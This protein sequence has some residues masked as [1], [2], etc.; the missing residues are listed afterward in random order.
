MKSR[1]QRNA[2]RIATLYRKNLLRGG[3]ACCTMATTRWLRI[4][5]ALAAL[6]YQVDMIMDGPGPPVTDGLPLRSVPFAA[7]DWRRYNVVKTLFHRG[8]D[9][10]S[11]TGGA[12]HP[13]IISKLGSVVGDHDEVAGVYF[14]GAERAAL[15]ETQRRI[16][17]ASRCVSLL[18]E[19]SQRLWE[20]SHGRRTPILLVPTG[21]DEVIPEPRENPY[22]SL[23]ERIAVY[24]GNLYTDSQREVNLLWQTRLQELGGLLR[25]KGIRLCLI[26]PG[27]VD[28]LDPACVTCLGPVENSRIWDYQYFAQAGIVLAQGTVQHNESS[29]IYYYLRTG[30]PVVSETPVPNNHLLK[31]TGLGFIASYGDTREMAQ[32]VEAAVEKKGEKQE[33]IGY[34]LR[35]H[36]WKQRA[37]V[38]DRLIQGAVPGGPCLPLRTL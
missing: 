34:M 25:K 30:L 19:A 32:L 21:V 5:E 7:F 28:K 24:I 13:F 20:A 26:G 18:T 3:V 17:A 11:A 29:K 16:Q 12:E 9:A 8:F 38:Y 6:G 2:L 31:D 10:L 27:R 14:F 33:A 1:G 37:Q 22:R 15:F 4:S 23:P 36:T 35:H